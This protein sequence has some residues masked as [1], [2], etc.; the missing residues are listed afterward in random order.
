MFFL[1]FLLIIGGKGAALSGHKIK[2]GEAAKPKTKTQQACLSGEM[3]QRNI[4]VTWKLIQL[5]IILLNTNTNECPIIFKQV[6]VCIGKYSLFCNHST[7]ETQ[8]LRQPFSTQNLMFFIDIHQ[9]RCLCC[10]PNIKRKSFCETESRQLQNAYIFRMIRLND[11]YDIISKYK[12]I[13]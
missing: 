3:D 13:G 4:A 6:N 8:K 2:D 10:Y 12:N 7:D 11:N 1:N 9:H 5:N